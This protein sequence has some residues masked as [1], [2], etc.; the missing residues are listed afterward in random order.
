MHVGY[1]LDKTRR[2]KATN[3]WTIP[4]YPTVWGHVSTSEPS[5]VAA[6][7][8]RRTAVCCTVPRPWSTDSRTNRGQAAID[9]RTAQ[10]FLLFSEIRGSNAMLRVSLSFQSPKILW[11]QNSYRNARYTVLKVFNNF[12]RRVDRGGPKRALA[13]CKDALLQ[14]CHSIRTISGSCWTSCNI[15]TRKFSLSL[16]KWQTVTHPPNTTL[17]QQKPLFL[18][19]NYSSA[20]PNNFAL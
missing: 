6:A 2:Y 12:K 10:F 13:N 15:V 11:R 9:T 5:Q 1:L 7:G 16:S 14:T 18:P 4:N 20:V 8:W 17:V 19:T 3:N